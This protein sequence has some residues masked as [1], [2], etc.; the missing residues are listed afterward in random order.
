MEG[1]IRETL[2]GSV[3]VLNFPAAGLGPVWADPSQLEN[4]IMS[5]VYNA[6]EAMP[7]GGSLHLRTGEVRIAEDGQADAWDI[8]PGD[9]MRPGTYA[10]LMIEDSGVGMKKDVLSRIFEP[11][12]TTKPMGKGTGLGL[13]TVYGVLKQSG[14]AIHADSEHG[15][16]ARFRLYLPLAR[17]GQGVSAAGSREIPGD[18]RP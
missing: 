11:F 12:F 13:S 2:G 5:L 9:R 8:L 6:R 4:C 17:P 10:L 14:G 15:K 3:H 16:G 1:A 7:T 18:T